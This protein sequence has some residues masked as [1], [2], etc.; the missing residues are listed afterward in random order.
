[1][2]RGDRV[3][4]VLTG[5]VISLLSIG[6]GCAKDAS[7]SDIERIGEA[8]VFS[9]VPNHAFKNRSVVETS[10]VNIDGSL[11]AFFDHEW[12]GKMFRVPLQSSLI[13]T[14]SPHLVIESARFP[15]TINKGGTLFNLA[16]V[17]G[18]VYLWKSLDLG[19]TWT[20]I[21][22]GRPVLN[23]SDDRSSIYHQLWNVAIDI[24]DDGSGIF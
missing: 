4:L 14:V 1:M 24:A 6:C 17:D 7:P 15:Y 16:T 11:I 13:A 2:A 10:L 21:N 20:K 18:N 19:L 8:T 5:L 22:G 23:R 3:S 9:E 12:T